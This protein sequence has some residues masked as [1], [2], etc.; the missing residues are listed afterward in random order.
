MAVY[1]DAR[2]YEFPD[3]IVETI[4]I[5]Q[6]TVD[7]STFGDTFERRMPIGLPTVRMTLALREPDAVERVLEA[8]GATKEQARATVES[9]RIPVGGKR[10][11]A[12]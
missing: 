1:T 6:R 12:L 5:E 4:S 11:I 3:G 2:R 8:L 9:Y 10:E 7:V